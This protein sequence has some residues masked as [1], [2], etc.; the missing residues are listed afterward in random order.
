MINCVEY[1]FQYTGRGRKKS[2]KKSSP[3]DSGHRSNSADWR[4]VDSDVESDTSFAAAAAA[5]DKET[6]SGNK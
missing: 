6:R 1:C 3:Q 5:A 2:G 4:H